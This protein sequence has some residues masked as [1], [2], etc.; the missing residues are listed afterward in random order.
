MIP[1]RAKSVV[2]ELIHKSSVGLSSLEI[3]E[4][5]NNRF[6]R[7]TIYRSLVKLQ[8][9]NSIQKVI[10]PQGIVKYIYC[11]CTSDA[12]QIHFCCKNC[13]RIVP[14]QIENHIFTL[15]EDYII[16]EMNLTVS[17]KCPSCEKEA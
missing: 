6:N 13:G 7:V 3:R 10:N 1:L 2:F 9:E 4:A 5:L 15:P 16:E 8:E 14:F 17:G 12:L 11:N